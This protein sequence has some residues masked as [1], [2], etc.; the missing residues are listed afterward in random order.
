MNVHV[1][2]GQHQ[3]LPT[4]GQFVLSPLILIHAH[5][6]YSITLVETP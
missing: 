6:N 5:P 4:H 2:I 3:Q 1:P